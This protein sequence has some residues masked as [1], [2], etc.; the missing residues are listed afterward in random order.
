[1][2][3]FNTTLNTDVRDDTFLRNIALSVARNMAGANV[4]KEHLLPILGLTD[5]EFELIAEDPQFERYVEQFHQ[6]LVNN[7]FSFEAKSR[8]LAEDLLPIAYEMASSITTPAPVRAKMIE[9][10]VEWGNLKP[11]SNVST[12]PGGAAFSISIN[13]PGSTG[14]T[15]KVITVT[16]EA[17]DEEK[18]GEIGQKTR[19]KG[20]SP[21]KSAIIPKDDAIKPMPVRTEEMKEK[22]FGLFDEGDDYVYAGDDVNL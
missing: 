18:Q 9:N 14:P 10:L 11:K 5:E 1:M 7:G 2:Q 19:K 4:P 21:Q 6:E 22:L 20:V 15:E 17:K 16:S 3:N 13:L 8:I 12:L